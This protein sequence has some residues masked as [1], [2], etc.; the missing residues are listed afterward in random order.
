M[1]WLLGE[2][3]C[4]TLTFTFFFHR[5]YAS[6]YKIRTNQYERD[7]QYLTHVDK[8]LVLKIYL[9]LFYKFDKEAERE[10]QEYANAEK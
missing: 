4:S 2:G 10:Y 3:R 5:L 9:T 8:H 6:Y 7:A 1:A